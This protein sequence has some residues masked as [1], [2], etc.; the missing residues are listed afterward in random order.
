MH[1]DSVELYRLVLPLKKPLPSPGGGDAHLET[2]L[3]RMRCGELS[4][5]GEASPGKSPLESEEWTA[6]AFDVLKDWL[7]P[8]IV[9]KQI[10]TGDDL[11]K[12]LA[13]FQGNRRAKAALD[14]AWWDLHARQL[15]SPLHEL[16]GGKKSVVE[17][18]V[19]FDRMDS[20]DDFLSALGRAIEAGY[21]RVKLMFRPGWDLRMLEAVR[22][23]FP[24][25]TFHVDVAGGLTIHHTDILYRL[26][27][28]FLAMVEQPLTA[29]DF[30]GHAMLQ[31]AMRTP[32]CLGRSIR[33]LS[34]AEMALELHGCK[35][36]SLDLGRVGGLTTALAIHDLC[37]EC[38]TPCY[39]GAVPQT[40]IAARHGFALAAME[41][42]SYPAEYFP[43]EESLA[44]DVAEP[45]VPLRDEDGIRRIHLGES[46]GIGI[47]PDEEVLKKYCVERVKV[48]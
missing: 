7:A 40:T 13:A 3:V 8:A 32:I 12:L 6:G 9:G 1:I 28:F 46:S 19:T 14:M 37:H 45:L 39:V 24:G 42:C 29:D 17:V 31:E 18:G 48:G 25:K 41:N 21:A 20:F 34:H 2:V 10:N 44:V 26:D 43:G 35:F 15:G 16:L 23:E 38:C 33:T 47:E 4:G 5:W 36:V 11:E 27:D 22:R 30:V